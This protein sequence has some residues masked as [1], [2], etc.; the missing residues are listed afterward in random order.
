MMNFDSDKEK[1]LDAFL[2]KYNPIPPGAKPNEY[3]RILQAVENSHQV[4]WWQN[5]TESFRLSL[6]WL[7]P[8]GAAAI[9]TFVFWPPPSSKYDPEVEQALSLMM[10]PL[11]S[12]MGGGI[13]ENWIDLAEMVST[14]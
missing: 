5:M 8:V 9:L 4:S 6:K 12:E 14:L 10:G 1:K 2:K 13:E 11:P 3:Q 7:L